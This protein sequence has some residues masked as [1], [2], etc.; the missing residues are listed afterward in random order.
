MGN[1]ALE[2]RAGF[3]GRVARAVFFGR[4]FGPDFNF[5]I[6]FTPLAGFDPA[7]VCQSAGTRWRSVLIAIKQ[8]CSLIAMAST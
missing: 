2:G 3:V 4:R 7:A 6:P 8:V 1:V 5:M